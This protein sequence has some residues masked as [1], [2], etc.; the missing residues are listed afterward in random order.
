MT[1]ATSFTVGCDNAQTGGQ[2]VSYIFPAIAE[3]FAR[4]FGREVAP[5]HSH[6][7]DNS[8]QKQKDLDG[9]IK[10]KIKGRT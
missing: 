1:R 10:E 5:D 8:D 6:H 9:I 4:P 2:E 3:K 7:E